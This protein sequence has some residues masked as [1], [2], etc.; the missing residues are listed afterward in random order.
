MN[1]TIIVEKFDV[2]FELSILER[3]YSILNM[4]VENVQSHSIR[5]CNQKKCNN[6]TKDCLI[7]IFTKMFIVATH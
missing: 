6:D 2:N 5:L 3:E 4:L 1:S 7:R